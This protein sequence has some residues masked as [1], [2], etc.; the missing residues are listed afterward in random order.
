[1]DQIDVFAV[2][3][4]PG[5]FTGLRVGLTAVKAWAEIHGKPIAAISGLEAIAAQSKAMSRRSPL[6]MQILRHFSMR[7]GGNFRFPV[8]DAGRT[9]QGM[10]E[11]LGEESIVSPEE[12]VA[13][14]KTSPPGAGR[15]LF[16][17]S[18]RCFPRLIQESFRSCASKLCQRF[19]RRCW[20]V[21]I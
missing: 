5:S 4:G 14:V 8:S 7:G 10:L 16:R 2:A 12:F 3:S 21:G 20:P 6:E 13:L 1:M 18:R 19:S 15:R 11:L 9:T 17:R